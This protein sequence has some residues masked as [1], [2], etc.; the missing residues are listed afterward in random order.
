[1][2][3]TGGEGKEGEKVNLKICLARELNPRE[4][5]EQGGMLQISKNISL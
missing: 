2:I 1:M 5:R 4:R 3:V